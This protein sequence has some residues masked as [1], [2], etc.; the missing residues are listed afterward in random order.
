[1]GGVFLIAFARGAKTFVS[2]SE[3]DRIDLV[4]DHAVE[5]EVMANVHDAIKNLSVG[6]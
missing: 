2:I 6:G 4:D 3:D 5:T 1:M